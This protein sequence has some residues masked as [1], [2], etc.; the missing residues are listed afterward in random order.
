MDMGAIFQQRWRKLND[1]FV[2]IQLRVSDA[3]SSIGAAAKVFRFAF[4]SVVLGFGAYLVIHQQMSP[5]ATIPASILTSRA[6][7]PIHT[8]VAHWKGFVASRLALGRLNDLLGLAATEPR[9]TALPAPRSQFT[10]DDVAVGISGST[11]ALEI[12]AGFMLKAGDGLLL[13]G[14][15]GGGKFTLVRSLAGALPLLRGSVRLDGATLEKWDPQQ[16]GQHVGY[17]PQDA[18]SF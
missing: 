4:E 11:T 3:S 2:I 7:A 13:I 18:K 15:S 16:L 9:S 12:G 1:N 5:G 17:M 14:P 10:A 8:A 6:L